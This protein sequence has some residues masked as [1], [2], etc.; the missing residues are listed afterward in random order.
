MGAGEYL[1][2]SR[3]KRWVVIYNARCMG[4]AQCKGVLKCA[5]DTPD[6]PLRGGSH[7]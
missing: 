6:L 5:Q 7:A 1:G 4:A 3:Y 2:V